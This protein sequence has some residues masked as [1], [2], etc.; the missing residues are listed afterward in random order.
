MSAAAGEGRA[1]GATGG[2]VSLAQRVFETLADGAFHS[3]AALAARLGLTRSA[4]WKAVGEL[5]ERG[6]EVQAV[7][8]RGYRLAAPRVPLDAGRIL[9]A[10]APATRARVRR[11]EV[12][13]QL[14]STN[15]E[16]LARPPPEP[17]RCDVLLAEFQSAGRGRHARRWVAPPGG[18]IC[19]SVSWAFAALPPGSGALS[20]AM[21]VAAL[22]AL[23]TLGELPVGL[24]WPNDLL[25]GA[26]KLGG[27]LLEMRSEGGGPAL[28]VFGIG[29]NVALGSEARAGIAALGQAATDL[30]ELGV[31][32]CDRNALAAAL[33]DAAVGAFERFERE[34]FAAFIERWQRADLLRGESVS[35][36]GAGG[37]A[38]FTG[39]AAGVDADG[40]LLVETPSGLRRFSSGEVSVRSRPD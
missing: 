26:R 40:A 22:E 1:G 11:C 35:L 16:L 33:V 21:G 23:A 20:L 25:A 17:G 10:L 15:S 32:H 36:T 5:R 27:M 28:L 7:T 24:K 6:L 18:A 29:L 8:N 38:E 19:L 9:A 34:G 4:V 37:N 14:G 3:G 2:G 31:A 30:A 12:A 39:R 13:W